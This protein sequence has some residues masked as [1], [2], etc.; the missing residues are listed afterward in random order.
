MSF[1]PAS[2][3]EV[4]GAASSSKP[5]GHSRVRSQV[6]HSF[7]SFRYFYLVWSTILIF[8]FLDKLLAE[9]SLG[10]TMFKNVCLGGTFDGIHAGHKLLF[11]EAT[12]LC[13]ERLVVGVTDSNMIKSKTLWELISPTEDRVRKVKEYLTELNP[14]LTYNVV[15]INDIYG[16]TIVE[17]DLECIVVSKETVKGADKINEA[18][19]K[20]GWPELKIHVVDL[21]EDT[22]SSHREAMER[23]REKKVSS[24][25]LRFEKLGTIINPP[26]PN[27]SIPERPYLIGLTGGVASGKTTISNYLVKTYGFGY[28]NYDTMGHKTYAEVGSPTYNKVVEHFGSSILNNETKQI[29]RSALGRIVF[30]DKASLEKLNELVWPGIYSLVDEE[31]EKQKAEHDVIILESAL[32]IESGQ[33][34]RVHQLWTSI[35]PP[36]EA[37]RRQIETRNLT[38][39]EAEAR[40]ARQTDNTTRIKMSNAIFCSLWDEEFTRRQ[41]DKCVKELKEKYL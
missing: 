15:P 2:E 28:V 8:M 5:P 13:S 27:N 12:R 34:K 38:R 33:T 32:L 4:R 7:M 3:S 36:E 37:I 17:K 1:S 11:G 18:R 39:E 22:N 41:V 19:M 26:I 6:G 31:I 29:D 40:V 25:L 35:I 16:P 9:V 23:L 20:K 24:S 14:K 10:R 21:L 30:K